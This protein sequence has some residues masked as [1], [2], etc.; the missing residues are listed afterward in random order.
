MNQPTPSV[1]LADVER[2][3]RRDFSAAEVAGVLAALETYGPESWH[4]EVPRVR[5]AILKLA[6][7]RP[8]QLREALAMAYQDYRDILVT[9][10]YPRY[11]RE[12]PPSVPDASKADRAITADWE[13][14]RDWFERR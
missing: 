7:G 14:Y 6:G 13:Q 4:R 8:D 5:L 9:A 11:F 12:I 3:A 2:I 1:T 10:E